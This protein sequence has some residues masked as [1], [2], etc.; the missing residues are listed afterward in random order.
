[1]K[2]LNKILDSLSI[3]PPKQKQ[4]K[5]TRKNIMV[6]PQDE[7]IVQHNYLVEARYRLSLQEKRV[8]LW[9]LTQ[10][11]SNDEDFKL[12]RLEIVEFAKMIDIAV[13]S[14]Y[15][16][17]RKITK[18]LIQRA[19]E[20]YNPQSNT[21]IQFSWLSFAQYHLT[22][23]YIELGFDPR[24]KPYLIQLKSHFTKLSMSDIM[25]LNSL[26][27]MR[28]YELLKQYE[29]IGQRE[30]SIKDLREYCGIAKHEYER[31]NDFK[32]DVLEKAKKEINEK[33]DINIDYRE[34][35]ESRKIV[36]IEWTIKQKKPNQEERLKVSSKHKEF[37]SKES[38][39]EAI[40]KYG[41]GRTSARQFLNNHKEED[42]KNA[43]RAVHLQI[44][45]NHVKNPKAML[46]IAIQ[47]QW[48][49][50]IFKDRNKN[51]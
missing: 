12:H 15:S 2:P 1:M 40:M 27:A 35:K 24:L 20:I 39:I 9:L 32:K 21:F 8:I 43:L 3:I 38:L 50:E 45:R 29:T 23:G 18:R 34:L 17:L 6:E 30:I 48:H 7:L 46:R 33:T 31:Y 44:E 14:R 42:I 37:R 11:K 41:F 25:Q 26:Y 51:D 47:E 19:V 5:K 4:I 49:P 10:I 28:F 16:E 36:A 13:D 22:K